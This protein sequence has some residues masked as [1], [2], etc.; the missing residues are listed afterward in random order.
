MTATARSSTQHQEARQLQPDG[1]SFSCAR[2]I[3]V[4]SDSYPRWTYFP[5]SAAPPSWVDPVVDVF[6][7]QQ[8]QIDSSSVQGLQSD[9]VLAELASGLR[10]LG[11]EVESGKAREDKIRRPVL[12]GDSGAERVSYEIDAWHGELGAVV[13]VEAGRGWMG[14]AIYRDL[15]RTSL[16]VGARFLVLAVMSEYRYK[17]SGRVQTNESFVL[18]RDQLDA[19]YASGRLSLPFEGVLLVGY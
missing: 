16:I 17:S 3:T 5:R 7:E 12:F 4:T 15:I 11:F 14:N 2:I 13:E 10:A 9:G 8:R 19:V 18:T 6:R 1:R